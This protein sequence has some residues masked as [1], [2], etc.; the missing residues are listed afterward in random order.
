MAHPTF[1]VLKGVSR[2]RRFCPMPHSYANFKRMKNR[3]FRRVFNQQ[4]RLGAERWSDIRL[5]CCH[6]LN[7]WDII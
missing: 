6:Y 2:C 3:R 5:K 7:G 1:V 4:V